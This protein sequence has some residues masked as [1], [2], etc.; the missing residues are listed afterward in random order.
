MRWLL[1]LAAL[2]LA[3]CTRDGL[4]RQEAYV[5]GTRV[6]VVLARADA[7][8]ARTALGEVLREFDRLH[9]LLH[10]WQPSALTRV[11][12]ALARGEA[13][14]VDAELGAMLADA[15]ALSIR[16]D[17]AFDPG[18]GALIALWGFQADDYVARLPDAA[19]LARLVA[20]H[21]SIARLDIAAQPDG[22]YRIRSDARDT[23]LDLGG[24]AKGYA[25]DRAAALLRQRGVCCAL[26]NIGGNVMALGDKDGQPWRIGIQ[27]PRQPEPLA[28]VELRD[29]EAIGSSGDYQR[30]FEVEGRRYCHLI[31]PRDGR[32]VAHTQAV[33][34]LMPPGPQAGTLSDVT[35]K[36]LF[37]GGPAHWREAAARMGVDAALRVGEHGEIEVTPAMQARLRPLR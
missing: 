29:G 11:N 28:M 4:Q 12:A 24:Y 1:L 25:L 22:R 13:I 27:H 7:D 19:E 26:I 32:P 6:E 23:R 31:D 3:G 2:L 5:F 30:Y 15:K 10:A 36:P 37:I 9:R 16:A 20:A 18:I 34:V 14:E 21:P 35:S 33:T 17:G 8:T